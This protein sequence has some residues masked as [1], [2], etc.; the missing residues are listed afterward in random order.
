MLNGLSSSAAVVGTGSDRRDIGAREPDNCRGLRAAGTRP[1][2]C[3][4]HPAAEPALRSAASNGSGASKRP[5]EITATILD[6]FYEDFGGTS[7]STPAYDGGPGRGEPGVVLRSRLPAASL[8][9][10]PRGQDSQDGKGPGA[11][12]PSSPG[13]HG[14]PGGPAAKNRRGR[15]REM[16]LCLPN[17]YPPGSP[18][19]RSVVGLDPPEPASPNGSTLA[20]SV[21]REHVAPCGSWACLLLG[22]V[23]PGPLG[24][25]TRWNSAG[26]ARPAEGCCQGYRYPR[27]SRSAAHSVRRAGGPGGVRP[28]G[29]RGCLSA[30]AQPGALG[31]A[32]GRRAGDGRALCSRGRTSGRRLV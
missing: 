2:R 3:A 26:T 31:A 16:I 29:P 6:P 32:R 19:R 28:A 10:L 11:W 4:A 12:R 7:G 21:L 13:P 1:P 30:A 8:K 14:F 20:T 15:S 18:A 5:A 24:S 9:P 22:G 25:A 23:G 27:R 17:R